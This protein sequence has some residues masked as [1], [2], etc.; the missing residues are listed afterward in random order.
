MAQSGQ[1][2]IDL[3]IQAPTENFYHVFKIQ[4]QHLPSISSDH[5]KGVDLHEG[6]WGKDGSVKTWK[7]TV[8]GKEES[9]KEKI[10]FDDEK[11]LV[12]FV[13]LHGHVFKNYKSWKNIFQATPKDEKSCVVKHILEYEKLNET[14]SE[15]HEY[16]DFMVKI[17][18]DIA[19]H[20]GKQA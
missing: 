6:E 8:G 19:A 2:E 13:G 3:E 1:L 10:F 12:T 15:P 14:V 9:Y 16:L 17:T 11:K 18:Q 4:C 7:Y 5:V 20:L